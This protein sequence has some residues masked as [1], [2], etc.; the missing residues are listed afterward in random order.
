MITSSSS[1]SIARIQ[2]SNWHGLGNLKC[3]II[4]MGSCS[5]RLS[6]LTTCGYVSIACIVDTL[7]VQHVKRHIYYFP[8]LLVLSTIIIVVLHTLQMRHASPF[9]DELILQNEYKKCEDTM[10]DTKTPSDASILIIAT[11]VVG[12][13][14]LLDASCPCSVIMSTWRGKIIGMIMSRMIEIALESVLSGSCRF[15]SSQV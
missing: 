3:Q 13:V 12:V 5:M 4:T 6:S 7:V 9:L 8:F 1:T 10:I 2:D 11:V 14:S 15:L